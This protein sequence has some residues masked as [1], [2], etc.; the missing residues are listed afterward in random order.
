V[1]LIGDLERAFAS[2]LYPS[3]VPVGIG[4]VVA[5]V[6]LLVI[7]RRRGWFAAARRHP[8]RARVLIATLLVIG[9][10]TGWYLGSPLFITASLEE[11]APSISPVG[12]SPRPTSIAGPAST[13]EAESPA[14]VANPTPAPMAPRTGTFHGADEFHF[15]RGTARLI[16]TSSGTYTLRFEDFSV[17]N[18]P[19]LFVYL[20]PDPDGYA[21]GAIE[22]GRLKATDGSF[23]TPVPEGA[24]VEAIRSVVI[25]CKQFSVQFA[26]AR[27]S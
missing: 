26:V 24:E 4:L 18:G 15:G 19:D 12:D 11:P 21:R 6:I 17:R 22:L 9:L 2:S 10:P 5:L 25:W 3:R 23:N 1:S 20:S 7:A 14:A 8:A 16:E 13:P 27:L